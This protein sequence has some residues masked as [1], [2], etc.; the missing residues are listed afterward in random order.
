MKVLIVIALVIASVDWG[1]TSTIS[2]IIPMENS[3]Y[4]LKCPEPQDFQYWLL[5]GQ[6]EAL[7]PDISYSEYTVY[8]NGSLVFESIQ[9][10]FQGT[11]LCI[12]G[13]ETIKSHPVHLRIRPLPPTNLWADVYESQFLT[14]LIAGLV[15]FFIFA[16]SCFVYNK[17]WRPAKGEESDESRIIEN[18]Y[19]NPA[20]ASTEDEDATSTKM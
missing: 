1:E 5:H 18:G 20:M 3:F 7:K 10:E 16:L 13:A 17:R 9:M 15:C 4:E 19:D 11:H 6:G 14:G 12:E 2:E 8:S